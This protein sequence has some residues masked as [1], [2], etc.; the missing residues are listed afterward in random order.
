MHQFYSA[1]ILFSWASAANCT[2]FVVALPGN[3][4]LPMYR[5]D[6]RC[7]LWHMQH[8]TAQFSPA[9][10][11]GLAQPSHALHL[12]HPRTNGSVRVDVGAQDSG[13]VQ[14][15]W[16]I[17]VVCKSDGSQTAA[18]QSQSM[19]FHMPC[20]T[21]AHAWVLLPCLLVHTCTCTY[22]LPYFK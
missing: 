2:V 4:P 8:F 21:G 6:K 7:H 11:V 1:S 14:P 10:S 18:P 20:I 15:T 9:I 3:V 16:P 22:L 17:Q 13:P 19:E 12:L 5:F